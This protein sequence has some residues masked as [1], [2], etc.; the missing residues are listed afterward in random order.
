MVKEAYAEYAKKY[1]LPDYDALDQEF[2]ISLIEKKEFLLRQIRRKM[3]E[4]VEQSI[5]LLH[6]ILQPDVGSIT[7]MHECTSCTQE[8]KE[9]LAELFREIMLVHR[10]LLEAEYAQDLEQDAKIINETLEQWPALR[11]KTL[12]FVKKMKTAW[13]ETTEV[14][15][16]LEYLG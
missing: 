6:D 10:A 4:R 9:Q 1:K 16:I 15:E 2:E 7:S 8:E 3:T 11:K 13:K 14:K 5:G 12:N